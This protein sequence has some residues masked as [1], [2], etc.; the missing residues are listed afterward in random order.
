MAPFPQILSFIRSEG[1]WK[2]TT[3]PRK[4]QQTPGTYPRPL[5]HRLMKAFHICILGYLGHV[6]G[7]LLEYSLNLAA[8]DPFW[9]G[10]KK[11]CSMVVGDLPP[12]EKKEVQKVTA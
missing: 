12:P 3:C 4:F 9:D 5:N 6:S 11:N 8:G 2:K 7:G 10:K 1:G